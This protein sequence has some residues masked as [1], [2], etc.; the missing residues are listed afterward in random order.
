MGF[1]VWRCVKVIFSAALVLMA[2]APAAAQEF[3]RGKTVVVLVGTAADG[4]IRYLQPHDGAPHRQTS[5]RQSEHC[6]AEH[7]GRRAA[8]RRQSFVQ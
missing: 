6:R 3:F 1:A 5:A 7:A 4:G 2:V 8:H